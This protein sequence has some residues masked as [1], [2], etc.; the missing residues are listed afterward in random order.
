MRIRLIGLVCVLFVV[1]VMLVLGI[2]EDDDVP[3]GDVP[4]AIILRDEGGV[5]GVSGQ[6]AYTNA[7]FT[8]GID[9]PLIILEDQT[10]FV[11]RDKNYI[12]PIASQTLGQITSNFYQSP[13]TYS[14]ALPIVPNAPRND[15]DNN[16][17]QDDGVMIFAIAYWNNSWGDAFLEERDQF[18]GGWSSA[19]ASMLVSNNAQTLGEYVGGKLLIFAPIEGQGFP[20]GF[21]ADGK[22]FTADDPIVIVPQGWTLVH[23]DTNPFTFDRSKRPVVD[24]LE[25]EGSRADDFSRLSYTAAFDAMLTKFRTEYAFTEHKNLDWDVISATFRPRFEQAERANNADLYASA[26]Y[27]FSLAIPDGHVSASFTQYTYNQFLAATEGGIGIALAELDDGRVIVS[28]VGAGTPAE[29][30]GMRQ[31][32]Q[33]LAIN[34]APINDA[35]EKARVWTTSSSAHYRRLV[36]LR[37]V[38]RF[39]VGAVVDMTFRNPN[40]AEQTVRF[41]AVRDE[42]SFSFS[43]LQRGRDPFDL[44]LVYTRIAGGYLYVKINSFFDDKRLT[45]ALWERMIRAARAQNVPA[46]ILD[47][48]TNAGGSGYLADQLAAYFFDEAHLLGN[49]G[50]Y[51]KELGTFYFDPEREDRYILPPEDL[52]YRGRV[53]VLVSP[54]CL[55]AC[56]FFSWNMTVA[57][58]AEIIGQYPTGGLGGSVQ[59]FYMP[60]RLEVQMTIGRAV[61]N[62]GKIHIE[63]TGVVPTVRVPVTEETL[64]AQDAVLD[65]AIAFLQGR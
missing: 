12:F 20:S 62:D 35:I 45:V 44:P 9:D 57:N 27:Q 26:L 65:A 54:T 6:V 18:G 43:S 33:V 49:A 11:N 58:R 7:F 32:T 14:L 21:G 38:T 37:Y 19:Y 34:G 56:E 61:D 60:S 52:R 64:F 8:A 41:N 53:V 30:A 36:Q 1:G 31:R 39:P 4:Q 55:S 40:E 3:T 28:Y 5:E 15:V 47:M 29:G 17:R 48:R 10:G 59:R 22:L 23:M 46:I 2:G 51:D 63:G 24:L 50:F 25:G 42:A 16:G 13:F